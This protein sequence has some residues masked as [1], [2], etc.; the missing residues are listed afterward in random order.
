VDCLRSGYALPPSAHA[1]EPSHPDCRVP[2]VVIGDRGRVTQ[3]LLNL[4]SNAVKYTHTG[5]V[6]LRISVSETGDSVC[7]L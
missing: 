3:I 5:S 6:K 2:A 4:M 7:R 1:G